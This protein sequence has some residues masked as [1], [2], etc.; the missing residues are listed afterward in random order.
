MR[1]SCATGE[2]AAGARW[3]ETPGG[4]LEAGE[5]HGDA[6]VREVLEETSL[7]ITAPHLLRE[8]QYE[9]RRGDVVDCYTYATDGAQGEVMLSD[10]H[11]RFDWLTVE[12]YAERYCPE[13]VHPTTAP[14]VRA[15]LAEMRA[16]CRLLREWLAHRQQLAPS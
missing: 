14:W 7:R 3:W 8:W 11:T 15:F 13:D 2:Q 12:E 1:S 16:D 9:N 6:I 10:E 4:T 5:S